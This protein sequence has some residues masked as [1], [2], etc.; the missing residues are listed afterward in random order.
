MHCHRVFHRI[1]AAAG[2]GPENEAHLLVRRNTDAGAHRDDGI[3]DAALAAGKLRTR[4]EGRRIAQRT[5][6]TDEG[7]TVGF[8]LDLAQCARQVSD[9]MRCMNIRV[10]RRTL[11]PFGVDGGAAI[12]NLGFHEHLRK[13]RMRGIA[14][15]VVQHQ[16]R[17][18][19]DLDHAVARAGIDDVEPAAFAVG[20]RRNDHFHDRLDIAC[21][22]VEFRLVFGEDG[23]GFL[24]RVAH[25]LTSRRPPVAAFHVAQEQERALHVFR[26]IGMEAGDV[27][28][29]PAAVARTIG[30][31]HQR[32]LAVRHHMHGARRPERL[33]DDAHWCIVETAGIHAH[34][35]FRLGVDH[36]DFARSLFLQEQFR[37]FNHRIIVETLAHPA[38]KDHIVDRDDRH[39][40][41]VGIIILHHRTGFA[42]AN[43]RGG[44]VHRIVEAVAPE[45]TKLCQALEV[46]H[47]RCRLILRGKQACIGR[48]DRIARQ[49]ALEA[50]IWHAKVG[51]LIIQMRI[52][53]IEGGFRNAPWQ[54]T[55]GRVIDLALHHKLVGLVEK[56]AERLGHDERRH[57]IFK[58]RAGPRQKRT[59]PAHRHQKTAELEPMLNRNIALGNGKEARQTR[60]RGQKVIA[61]FVQLV[62]LHAETDG[63]QAAF[64]ALKEAELHIE[65]KLARAGGKIAQPLTQCVRIVFADG[66]VGMRLAGIDQNARPFPGF[67]AGDRFHL[68]V[69]FVHQPHDI[70]CEKR[71]V[72]RA[73]GCRFRLV[74]DGCHGTAEISDAFFQTAAQ[75]PQ[76]TAIVRDSGNRFLKNIVDVDDAVEIALHIDRR[77]FRP[78]FQRGRKRDQMTGK[79]AAIHG[80]HIKRA[81]R[82]QRIGFIP[83]VEVALIFLHLVERAEGCFDTIQRFVEADPAEIT[84][85]N[86]GKKIDADIGG[87]CALRHDRGRVFLEIIR[88][89]M[90]VFLIGEFGKIA[91]GAAR[92]AA[93]IR[94]VGG[95]HFQRIL[96]LGRAADEPC[97]QR[98]GKPDHYKGGSDK[99][100]VA[101]G[102]KR[103]EDRK[104]RNSHRGPHELEIEQQRIG[105][106]SGLRR[107]APFQKVAARDEQAIDR[108]R[109]RIGHQECGMRD[110]GGAQRHIR[111]AKRD[112]GQHRLRMTLQRII[113]ARRNKVRDD[114]ESRSHE[115]GKD[116]EALPDGGGAK[117]QDTPAHDGCD[118][119]EDRIERTAQVIDHFPAGDGADAA[120]RSEKPRQKLPVATRPAVVARHIDIIA[121]R[122]I[123]HDL[124]VANECAARITTFKKIVAEQRV[125]R[126]AAFKRCLKGVDIVKALAGKRALAEQVLIGIGYGKD[127][128]IDTAIDRKDALEE[129]RLV[130]GRKR[131]R[132]PRL[133]NAIAAHDL[134]CL[135]ID[136]RAVHRVV[137]LACQM[138]DSFRRQAGIGIQRH[139]IFDVFRQ[140]LIGGEEAR[141]LIA[142]QEQ[143]QLMQLAAL[144]L[145]AHPAALLFIEQAAAIQKEEARLVVARIVLIELGDFI[146]RIFIDFHIRWNDFLAGIGPVT[147]ERK[148][149][150]AAR[151]G[152]IVNFQIADLLV[153]GIARGDKSRHRHQRARFR[154]QAIFIFKADQA[155]WLHEPGH[156]HIEQ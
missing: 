35:I 132:N 23:L 5:P 16:F 37:R 29:V 118:Q 84:R 17:I 54:A 139:D 106:G 31:H 124:D 25:R 95:Q 41:V 7:A 156:Q 144:A 6:A 138:R 120:A 149:D 80:R 43:A 128:R 85:G 88:R 127:I 141:I 152:Q 59:L 56:R 146:A 72:D 143:V 111:R 112:I 62:F 47:R 150:F 67:G 153:D 98:R 100:R 55:R 10:G 113:H 136:D 9:E 34:R 117:R 68:A 32:I 8:H 24:V 90:V 61:A 76:D 122:V 140:A 134:A 48:D 79:V 91:P 38:F 147:D 155:R 26:R 94:L 28:I 19:R 27:P 65:G 49:A 36:R 21:G 109:N 102:C 75:R 42:F 45:R 133:E 101:F 99:C 57:Q 105:R 77:R 130:A 53:R 114:A 125:F 3:K 64:L 86:N 73:E 22:L 137:Q 135:L 82:V 60:F 89:Q 52:A 66:I 39:A 129:G 4:I 123:F 46:G 2:K 51:I 96:R 119:P 116:E 103:E 121:G 104:P 11:A 83:V 107:R 145:P 148:I 58:H 50:E 110:E 18:G 70:G 40:M 13:C 92:I 87:R 20:F 12:G 30:R 151:I 97:N 71:Q 126:H 142:A 74:L 154:W 78:F 15:A 44:K 69:Q 33:V 63:E 93:Q 1:A 81:H 14:V 108:A 115:H 131:R